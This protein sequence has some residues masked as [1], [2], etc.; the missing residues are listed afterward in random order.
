[1]R[2]LTSAPV[3]VHIATEQIA[4]WNTFHDAFAAQFGFP[5]FYGRNMNAWIDC[6]TSL[7]EAA[8]LSKVQCPAGD[9]VTIALSSG[10]DFAQ[11]CPEQFTALLECSAFVNWRRLSAGLRPIL[12]LAY[13]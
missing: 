4:D 13:T 9:V 6:M 3:V 1:M 7:D 8:G 11:R 2:E 12:C 10:S 5:A